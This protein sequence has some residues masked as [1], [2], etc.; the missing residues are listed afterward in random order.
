MSYEIALKR[1]YALVDNDDGF[2]ILTDRLW[3]R[4]KARESLSLNDWYVEASPSP[5][6]RRQFHQR[7]ISSKVF[8]IRYRGELRDNPESLMPLM[9]YARRNR[10]TL[11]TAS[12]E[13][14]NSYL[15]VLRDMLV[16]ALRAEDY[17]EAL[18]ASPTCFSR[19]SHG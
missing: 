13:L 19:K 1:I 3:P 17:D 10:L 9:R 15:I 6:L 14:E 16:E 18:P 8:E 11:L 7:V 2:R 4:G 12:R 5:L